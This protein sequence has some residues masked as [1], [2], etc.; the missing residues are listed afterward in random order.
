MTA[1]AQKT[2]LGLTILIVL[3]LVTLLASKKFDVQLRKKNGLLLMEMIN[4]VSVQVDRLD[5]GYEGI[6]T[7]TN[8]ARNRLA[9]LIMLHRENLLVC[10]IL[11]QKRHESSSDI[12]NG[13]RRV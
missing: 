9:R 5:T 8:L 1:F 3:G 11:G 13:H 6:T 10:A 12:D 4:N 2:L 7:Q